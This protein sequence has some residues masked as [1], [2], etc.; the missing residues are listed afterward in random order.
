MGCASW[1]AGAPWVSWAGPVLGVS[2]A[3]GA[4]WPSTQPGGPSAP[5][6][7]GPSCPILVLPPSRDMQVGRTQESGVASGPLQ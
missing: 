3:Q 6:A 4:C 5:R 2:A 7:R 1:L